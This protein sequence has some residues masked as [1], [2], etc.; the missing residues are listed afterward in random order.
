VDARKRQGLDPARTRRRR[1]RRLRDAG[2]GRP[3]FTAQGQAC[4]YA[5]QRPA[6]GSF[7]VRR[8]HDGK[9]RFPGIQHGEIGEI[10]MRFEQ[11][12]EH[13]RI[14][15]REAHQKAQA[16]SGRGQGGAGGFFFARTRQGKHV[17]RVVPPLRENKG[18]WRSAP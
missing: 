3:G 10:V 2:A 13:G 15:R 7:L 1:A 16:R 8:T 14:P 4:A 18:Q 9:K 11:K 6:Y 17:R 12:T 5:I